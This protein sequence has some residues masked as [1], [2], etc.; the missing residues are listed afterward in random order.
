MSPMLP[1]INVGNKH[2]GGYYKPADNHCSIGE[3]FNRLIVCRLRRWH[4]RMDDK[5]QVDWEY[6]LF[7]LVLVAGSTSIVV[8]G[9][10]SLLR[11]VF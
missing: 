9:I 4:K 10:Y 8:F 2:N 7:G 5:Y 6:R 1:W 11:T 3:L